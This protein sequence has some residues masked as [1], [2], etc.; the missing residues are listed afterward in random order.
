MDDGSSEIWNNWGDEK[1]FFEIGGGRGGVGW[2][3]GGCKQEMGEL[4]WVGGRLMILH[5][6]FLL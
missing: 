3:G 2:G 4:I 6:L 5:Q 1:K